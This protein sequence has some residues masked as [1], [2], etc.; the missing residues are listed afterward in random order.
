[1]NQK[2][3]NYFYDCITRLSY[4]TDFILNMIIC[5]FLIFTLIHKASCIDQYHVYGPGELQ[6]VAINAYLE[7]RKKNP[8]VD[9]SSEN[10]EVMKRA[11]HHAIKRFAAHADDEFAI[12]KVY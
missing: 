4:P 1:M 8:G 6:K 3:G 7:E 2:V 11:K 5:A 12:I 10:S 9:I